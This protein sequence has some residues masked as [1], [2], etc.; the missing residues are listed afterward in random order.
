MAEIKAFCWPSKIVKLWQGIEANPC[1]LRW[2]KI[3]SFYRWY[4]EKRIN[5]E[6]FSTGQ[7]TIKVSFSIHSL[8]S[9]NFFVRIFLPGLHASKP[10]LFSSISS[11]FIAE[12]GNKRISSWTMITF[13]TF[14]NCVLCLLPLFNRII[15][16]LSS[17][18]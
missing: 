6:T 1:Y 13:S 3:K 16:F 11:Y 12:C 14:R 18:L 17:Q 8:M 4:K 2:N 7:R 15:T 9:K 10:L 5:N